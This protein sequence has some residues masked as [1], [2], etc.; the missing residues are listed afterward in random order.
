MESSANV[1][2]LPVGNL[3]RKER[4][5]RRLSVEA[6]TPQIERLIEPGKYYLNPAKRVH[7][8]IPSML[9]VRVSPKGA[10]AWAI[11]LRV[12]HAKT[13][14]RT[15]RRDITL[16]RFPAMPV[17]DAIEQGQHLWLHANKG[18]DPVAA[19]DQYRRLEA[20]VPT[21]EV[22]LDDFAKHA[23]QRSASDMSKV[24]KH[25]LPNI[26]PT[27]AGLIGR[28]DVVPVLKRI[29]REGRKPS[30]VR[31][32]SYIASF[33]RWVATKYEY[34]LDDWVADYKPTAPR[35]KRDRVL[36]WDEIGAVMS[37]AD[38]LSIYWKGLVKMLMLTGL[39]RDEA[40]NG[41]WSEIDWEERSWTIPAERMKAKR[42]HKLPLT[43]GIIEILD[44]Q[45]QWQKTADRELLPDMR[46]TPFI[47]TSTGRSPVS[48][49]SKMK[50]KLDGLANLSEPW[51]L[52]DFRRTVAT[53]LSEDLDVDADLADRVLAHVRVGIEGVYNKAT[54]YVQRRDAHS[55]W[56]QAIR[57]H[58]DTTASLRSK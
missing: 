47:F 37:A 36:N 10:K 21:V 8:T 41:R 58:V 25:N 15:V 28:E 32:R 20:E 49:H 52:H 34:G 53:R 9:H 56:E 13:G 22:L 11:S 38:G 54:R 26:L 45:R 12:K 51:T 35:G 46:R 23:P 42:P 33:Q 57:T 14:K 7:R 48:G 43:E 24:I 19:Q 3:V 4:G 18:I 50:A 40:S 30:T 29:G 27:S 17:A 6:S 2:K 5:E 1:V 39:R 16:G 31:L 55:M 44:A